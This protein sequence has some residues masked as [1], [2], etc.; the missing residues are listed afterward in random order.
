MFTID[1][2]FNDI[3][4]YRRV[5]DSGAQQHGPIADLAIP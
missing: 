1:L 3:A 4:V 2:V 5:M